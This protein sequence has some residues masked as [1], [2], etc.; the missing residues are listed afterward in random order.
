MK[1]LS[2]NNLPE[3]IIV[4]WPS[5]VVLFAKYQDTQSVGGKNCKTEWIDNCRL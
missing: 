1:L 2:G 4:L 5:F 3:L